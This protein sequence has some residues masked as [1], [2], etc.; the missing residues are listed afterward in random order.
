ERQSGRHELARTREHEL[1]N[2]ESEHAAAGQHAPR[3]GYAHAA[4]AATDIEHG[5]AGARCGAI[6]QHLGHWREQGVLLFLA[7]H[8]ALVGEAV[9][10]GDLVG[11]TFVGPGRGHGRSRAGEERAGMSSSSEMPRAASTAPA[12]KVA[13]GPT[14][15]QRNPASTLATTSAM[16]LAKLNAP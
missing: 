5:L 7:P 13:A 3:E 9:R 8:P 16:P 14:C 1:R 2:I 15:A 12:M 10:G 6:Q 11:V 4:P